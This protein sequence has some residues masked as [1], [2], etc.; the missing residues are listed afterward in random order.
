MKAYINKKPLRII[1][2]QVA[3][4]IFFVPGVVASDDVMTLEEAVSIGLRNNFNIQIA[5]NSAEAARNDTG[6]GTAGFLPSRGSIRRHERRSSVR[7]SAG[8]QSPMRGHG[9]RARRGS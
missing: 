4:V 7:A 3:L 1:L 2:W 9:R 6:R 8:A 5:H